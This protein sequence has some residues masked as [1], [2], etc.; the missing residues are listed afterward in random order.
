MAEKPQTAN[1]ISDKTNIAMPIKNMIGIIALICSFIFAYTQITSRLTSLET[2][3]ELM[4]ADLL[5]K[6]EQT[7]KNLEIYMLIEHNATSLEKITKS[8]ESMMNNR[9]N[10]DFLKDQVLKLQKDVES[11]KDKVRENKN[12]NN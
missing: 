9:L 5:K 10:I 7:P 8:I 12:G 11:L 2:K 3:D 6:A 1:I 4:S